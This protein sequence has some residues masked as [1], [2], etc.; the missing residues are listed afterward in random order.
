MGRSEGPPGTG[1]V[2]P[3]MDRSP[4]PA[5]TAG[6]S[7]VGTLLAIGLLLAMITAGLT[8][9]AATEA[10]HVPKADL[11]VQ[12]LE[13]RRCPD[14]VRSEAEV[15]SDRSCFTLA[16][17]NVGDARALARCEIT[18]QPSGAEVR[19][20]ANDLSVYSPGVAAG[21]IDP[22]LITVDGGGRDADAI[23]GECR[24]VPPPGD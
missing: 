24:L 11:L 10:R 22:L 15:P 21:D 12:P 1:T 8:L 23:G 18:A 5:S 16:V 3:P 9:M 4:S 14:D 6:Q 2:T 13:S 19:F 17:E 20:A 7:M